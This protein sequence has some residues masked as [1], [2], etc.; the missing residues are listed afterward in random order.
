MINARTKIF[1]LSLIWIALS[2]LN[3]AYSMENSPIEDCLNNGKKITINKIGDGNDKDSFNI[4]TTNKGELPIAKSSLYEEMQSKKD[5]KTDPIS[6][7]NRS[8]EENEKFYLSQ[9]A[10]SSK[11]ADDDSIKDDIMK[12]FKDINFSMQKNEQISALKKGELIKVT[13]V[14]NGVQTSKGA[15]FLLALKQLAENKF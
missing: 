8:D 10:F 12:V 7:F 1:I 11:I 15:S 13:L 5:L 14:L 2:P 3:E 9:D 4:Y 6:Y